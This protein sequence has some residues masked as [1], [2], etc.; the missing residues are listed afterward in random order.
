LQNSQQFDEQL[1]KIE[2]EKTL[3]RI[4]H[5][6]LVM[7]GKGGVGKSTI[8]AN[9]ATLLS[10][11]GHKTGLIDIDF[12]GPSIPKIMGLENKPIELDEQ[13]KIIPLGFGENLRIMSLGLLLK[14]ADDAVIWRGPMKMGAIKQLIKD[15]KW[16]ELDFLILDSPPGTGDEPLSVVQTIEKL[17]GAVI[18]TTPQDISISDVR[19]SV[20]FCEKLNLPVL[21]VIENMS[22]F[23]CPHCGETVDI[24][25]KGGGEVMASE[26]NVPFLGR[27][28]LEQDIVNAS[29]EGKPFVY[30][31][32]KSQS[33][34]TFEGITD[35][36]LQNI[37]TTESESE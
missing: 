6:I 19:R 13:N 21:G 1:E 17:D 30:F 35:K 14:G 32:G 12:H 31:Y 33:A 2:L 16:G 36:M 34:K 29:D 22:G 5:K 28:P 7:S 11:N 4:K 9:L 18:V 20:R 3:D 10:L 26:M 37:S 27:I 23:V 15:V 8:A 24:F 25:K